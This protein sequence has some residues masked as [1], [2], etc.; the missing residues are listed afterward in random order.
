MVGEILLTLLL[1]GPV[2]T[3]GAHVVPERSRSLQGRQGAAR[4]ELTRPVLA[5]QSGGGLPVALEKGTKMTGI[6]TREFSRRDL[7]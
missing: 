2:R 4:R 3:N 1:R 5:L 6:H 7:E